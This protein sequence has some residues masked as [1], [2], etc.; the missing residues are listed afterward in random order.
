MREFL[1]KMKGQ[2]VDVLC[3][4]TISLRGEIMNVAE[5]VLHLK[6]ED[7]QLCYVALDKITVVWE[8]RDKEPR[9]GFLSGTHA[10]R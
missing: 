6:D 3:T 10:G 9:A 4:G 5:S 8:A 1:M 2:R 7:G